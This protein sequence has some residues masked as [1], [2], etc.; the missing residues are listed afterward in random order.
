MTEKNEYNNECRKYASKTGKNRDKQNKT[1]VNPWG[2]CAGAKQVSDAALA[3][4]SPAL[5][6]PLYIYIIWYIIII[7]IVD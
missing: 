4:S 3:P 5:A 2:G 6:P 7:Y 1:F